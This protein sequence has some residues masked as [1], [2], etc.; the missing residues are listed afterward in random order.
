MKK[1]YP[2]LYLHSA[3][4]ANLVMII[5]EVLCID[6]TEQETLVVG[7]FLHDI[8]KMFIRRDMLEKPGSLTDSEWAEIKEHPRRGAF[9]IAVM[10][11]DKDLVKMI[12]YH[13][14]W[15]NG[16]GY[17]GLKGQEIPLYA[18]IIAVADAF[19]AMISRRAYRE[20][21]KICEAIEEIH[22]MA[23]IQFDPNLVAALAKDPFWQIYTYHSQNKLDRQVNHEKK[24][25][26]KLKNKYLSL[27]HPLVLAQSQLIDCLLDGGPVKAG[28]VR[29]GK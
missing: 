29:T 26:K 22:R 3:S 12:R 17:E 13:H 15:W 21:Y 2:R 7:A 5:C 10:G 9:M 28:R 19:D 16:K 1:S 8:G 6:D 11:M 25:L 14:E 24:R 4:V 23:G 20:A 18:R 27:S